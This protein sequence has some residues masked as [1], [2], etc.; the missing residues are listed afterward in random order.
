MATRRKVFF[1]FH[2]EDDALQASQIRNAGVIEG[3]K[4]L[5]DND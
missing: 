1:G 4:P 3:D 5:S 2:S